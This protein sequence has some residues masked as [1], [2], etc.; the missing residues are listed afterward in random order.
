MAWDTLLGGSKYYN[1]P[2]ALLGALMLT[3]Q[4]T[5]LKAL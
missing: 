2:W 3:G 5:N 1:E 4:L